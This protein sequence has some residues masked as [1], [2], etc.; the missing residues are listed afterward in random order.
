L[1]LKSKI[2]HVDHSIVRKME[3]KRKAGGRHMWNIFHHDE[4]EEQEP[5][6]GEKP[7]LKLL[8]QNCIGCGHCEEALDIV[9]CPPLSMA[10]CPHCGAANFVPY[11]I[12]DYWLYR[13]LGGGG[14]GSVYQAFYA[15][16]PNVEF[17]VKVLPR[18][19]LSDQRLVESLL[20]EAKLGKAFGRHPHLNTVVD[21]GRYHEEYFYAMEFCAGKRLDQVIES[22]ESVSQKYVLLWGM[23]LLSA[24]QRVFDTG[25][26]YRD[27]KPQNIIIDK[28]G[29]A[30]LIDYGLC[31]KID[32]EED[33][34][35]NTVNGSPLYMPPERVVG[36]R[37]GMSSEI[38]SLGM[39]LFHALTRKTY[40]SAS[41]VYELAKK[42]V[43]SLRI[44]SVETRLPVGVNPMIA[45]V[46]DKMVARLPE[47]RY[48]T[49]K[50]TVVALKE[51]YD[52][53]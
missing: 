14:M 21:F 16:D 5:Q 33:K 26:L 15:K 31:K 40:Y 48:Q 42:H 34:D 18:N 47:N 27:L 29:N 25:Y 9:D 19:S 32:D 11:L 39:V 35:S 43:T 20:F 46:L 1:S 4:D 49:F 13:P 7:S 24:E 50:E 3:R 6:Y 41:G 23:Q 45:L 12:K 17:A 37:E 44:S 28:D 22:L 36:M 10:K 53:L 2:N 38:Y 52:K 8:S 51:I 30:H